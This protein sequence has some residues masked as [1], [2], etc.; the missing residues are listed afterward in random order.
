MKK[1]N[2]FPVIILWLHRSRDSFRKYAGLRVKSMLLRDEKGK[3]INK[4]ERQTI[5]GKFL[6]A[7]RSFANDLKQMAVT[8][9]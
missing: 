8:K 5:A 3:K 4:R 2:Y 7:R 9:L 6:A 1:R